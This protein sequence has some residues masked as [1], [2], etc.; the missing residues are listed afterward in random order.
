LFSDETTAE[1]EFRTSTADF[2]NLSSNLK[3]D[4]TISFTNKEIHLALKHMH[5][6]KAPGPNKFNAFFFQRYWSFI[7]LD[8]STVVLQVLRG[9]L[10]PK[11]LNDTFIALIPKVSHPERVSQ[12]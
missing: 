3:R 10:I 5:P 8:V 12:F 9:S 1:P 2:P 7:E 4:L 6:F 11:G